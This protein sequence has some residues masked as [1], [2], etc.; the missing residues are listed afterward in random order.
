MV[1]TPTRSCLNSKQG[2]YKHP[3]AVV[4][5]G[6]ASLARA[7]GATWRGRHGALS[8]SQISHLQNR[9]LLYVVKGFIR[10]WNGWGGKAECAQVCW[11]SMLQFIGDLFF[12]KNIK[13]QNGCYNTRILKLVT[14]VFRGN[15]EDFKPW[16]IFNQLIACHRCYYP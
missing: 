15:E 8:I 14:M 9:L 10:A 7:A 12:H 4:Y 3:C 13:L 2:N 1:T 5:L 6:L 16:F 11:A